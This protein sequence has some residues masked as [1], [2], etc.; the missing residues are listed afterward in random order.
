MALTIQNFAVRFAVAL[1]FGALIGLERQWRQ[2][3][4]GTR[5]NALVAGG[6]AA[7]VMSGTL[8]PGDPTA[9]GRIVSYVVSGIGFLGAGVIFKE[10]AQIRGLNTA[11][12]IWCSAAVGVVTALGYVHY[13]AIVVGGVLLANTALRPLAY[14]LHPPVAKPE[15]V[16]Y[17]LELVCRSQE[18]SRV[19]SLLLQTV[20]RLPC[21]L[22][23]L[24]SEDQPAGVLVDA[25]LRVTGRN[26]EMLE[27]IVTRLSLEECVSAISWK[28]LP[29]SGEHPTDMSVPIQEET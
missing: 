19:R 7:F 14:K 26:D 9:Q 8:V 1:V 17:H 23:A 11:A 29:A 21:A 4:A 10:S 20:N 5:T 13:A 25:D 15:E 2:R 22:Y 12:T 24:R 3:M 6:A 27:Q 16:C 28:L 18:E